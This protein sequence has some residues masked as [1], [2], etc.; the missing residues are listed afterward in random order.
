MG[1][2]C[3]ESAYDPA[4]DQA[5]L[6]IRPGPSAGGG[7]MVLWYWWYRNV[8]PGKFEEFVRSVTEVTIAPLP[9]PQTGTL[10]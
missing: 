9:G 6:T 10:R 7:G 3:N 1:R 2:I 8:N 5:T 4:G